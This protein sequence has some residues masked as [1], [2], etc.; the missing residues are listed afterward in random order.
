MASEEKRQLTLGIVGG[1]QGG[2]EMLKIFASSNLVKVSYMVDREVKAPGMVEAKVLGVQQETDLVAAV[3]SHRTDF[4]IEAT[5]S[6]KV[7]EIIEENKNP[8]TELISAKGS[9]MFYNVL[10]ESRKK[11]NQSVSTQIGT[12]S[13]EIT[14]S[15]KTIKGALGGITQ[16]ALNLE[17]LA[18]N[19]AIE[20][21][22]AGEKGRSFAVVAEAVK[23]TADEAKT[24]L[25]SIESV[26]N[27]NSLMSEQLEELLEQ[28][29]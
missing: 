21:A 7:Q 19:A 9:L 15:T 18:I 25:E 28:L 22:R 3:K 8:A 17:M 16:V 6:P 4:I 12:I 10:N 20:A 14:E 29:N 26:N 13:E 11:T 23:T 24:L 2:L 5:G 27:D 1:G